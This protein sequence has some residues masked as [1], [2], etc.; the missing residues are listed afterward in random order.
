MARLIY[1]IVLLAILAELAAVL[2]LGGEPAAAILQRDIGIGSDVGVVAVVVVFVAFFANRIVARYFPIW[3]Y[4]PSQWR[5]Q[6]QWQR[7][8]QHQGGR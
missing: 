7:P 8:D 5:A 4:R 6:Q 2:L 3:H 1:W